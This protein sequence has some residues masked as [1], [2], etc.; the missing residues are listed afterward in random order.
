MNVNPAVVLTFLTFGHTIML[1]INGYAEQ[2]SI[3]YLN[4]YSYTA[5]LLFS[6]KGDKHTSNQDEKACLIIKELEIKRNF[7]GSI[8]GKDRQRIQG[9]N[10]G[11][12][13]KWLRPLPKHN[14]VQWKGK[15]TR[16]FLTN[17]Q[18]IINKLDMILHHMEV[19]KIDIGFITETW[20]NNTI[21]QELVISQSKNAG[22]TIIS[23]E[24]L[25]RKGGGVI[26]IYKSGLK[27][28]KVRSVMK[29]SFEGLIIRFQQTL[30]AST[31]RP[32]YSRKHAVNIN[33][34]LDEFGEIVTSLLQENSQTII[35]GDFNVLWNLI[36]HTNTK[37]LND[38]LNTFN[39]TE[40]IDFP[41]HKA[42]N[43]LDWII[44]K[45]QQNCIH[46]LIKLEFLSDHCN[47]RMDYEKSTINTREKGKTNKEF[48]NI[49]TEQFNRDL[50]NKLD[51]IQR[52]INIQVGPA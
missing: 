46:N 21:D 32:P 41:T 47:H 29:K 16:F 44:H 50:M 52:D 38:I 7:R 13:E 25:N 27:V 24:R 43:I 17:A 39:L 4:S 36:E 22:Y 49:N 34:F 8:G 1:S 18:S 40:V 6:L 28:E 5:D 42:G 31:Y 9:Q 30:F 20:I 26:C 11:I 2:K 3:D 15:D 48:K 35:I 23:H 19:D 51:N 37:R 45:E 33:T 12:H 10:N 14:I